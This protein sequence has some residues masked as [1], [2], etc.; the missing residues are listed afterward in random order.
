[1]V[2]K[3]IIKRL[4]ATTI[5]LISANPVVCS[6]GIR[7]QFIV[8]DQNSIIEYR[9]IIFRKD[10]LGCRSDNPLAIIAGKDEKL[11]TL[12][13]RLRFFSNLNLGKSS[14][15]INAEINITENEI[16]MNAKNDKVEFRKEKS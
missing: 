10:K 9:D 2:V 6:L 11:T 16:K 7:K 1:M 15:I 3:L 12:I 14:F 13:T 4:A 8:A 5:R